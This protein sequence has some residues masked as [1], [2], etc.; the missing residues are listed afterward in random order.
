M[1]QGATRRGFLKGAVAV[2]V[3]AMIE[4][5]RL[6][7]A[8]PAASGKAGAKRWRGFNLLEKFIAARSNDPFREEDFELIATWGF[9]FV[10][11]PMS[12]HCWSDPKNWREFREPVLREI[13]AAV[14]LGRQYGIHVNLCFH[15]APGYSVD[16]STPEPFNLW[17]D[18]E[19]LEACD[20]HWRHF[21]R[22]YRNVPASALSFNLLNE[23]ATRSGGGNTWVD[24]AA[25]TRVV[26]ALVAGIRAES[27]DRPI[28]AD[29]LVWGRVP[30]PD[31]AG[32]GIMQSLHV[33]DP[34][35]VTHWH[36]DWIEGSD[37]WPEPTW[38]LAVTPG[39]AAE[40]KERDAA[41]RR[42]FHNNP[43]A[44]RWRD[45]IDPAAEWNRARLDLQV[46]Q[47]W[48]EIEAAGSPVHIGEFGAFNRT[49]H[50]V[51]ISWMRDFLALAAD[52]G[53][54]WALWQFRGAFG[55]LDSGRADVKYEDFRA[56]K[57]DREMLEL[58][59]AS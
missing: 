56:H 55:V 48:R 7:G 50:H 25:Y 9:N 14:A 13:D 6:R 20:Y 54:G 10:R 45:R 41:F 30:V 35:P 40:E 1:E 53:F 39:A 22:R 29:G 27:P 34:I 38:P 59:R 43:I 17:T 57:L 18:S 46:F 12:Y 33:Y 19:A 28:I 51:V 16:L 4:R 24:G 23:P 44:I 26:R 21:A 32:L 5:I 52:S 15:R 11:L 58:L 47:P 36:A 2:A 37:R 3:A 42:V 8:Q 31:L 49:P